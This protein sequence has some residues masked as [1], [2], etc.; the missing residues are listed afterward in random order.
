MSHRDNLTPI[1]SDISKLTQSEIQL[2]IKELHFKLNKMDLLLN[3]AHKSANSGSFVLYENDRLIWSENTY[4]LFGWNKSNLEPQLEAFYDHISKHDRDYVK[5]VIEM[6]FSTGRHFDISFRWMGSDGKIKFINSVGSL[7]ID[8]KTGTK[9]ITG[10]SKDVS[11]KN[12]I[13]EEIR[14]AARKLKAIIETS[15]DGYFVLN[16][17]G[18]ITEFNKSF[19]LMTGYDSSELLKMSISQLD[20]IESVNNVKEHIKKVAAQGWDQFITKHKRK[21]G[22]II[23]LDIST[24]YI[25]SVDPAFICFARDITS[26]QLEKELLEAKFRIEIFSYSHT[27]E[28]LLQ[29]CLEE[30]KELTYSKIGFYHFVE[31]DQENLH[32][33]MWSTNTITN[34]C[35]AEGKDTHYE[36]SKA[37]VWVDCVKTRK[38]I[39]HNDYENLKHKTGLPE[40]HA[41]FIREL[42]V[43]VIKN[44]KIKAILGVGNKKTNYVSN[45]IEVVTKL[46]DL[47]WDIVERKRAEEERNKSEQK[48]LELFE[49]AYV[50]IW[51]EDFSE[52]KKFIDQRKYEGVS[53][54][55]EYFEKNPEDIYKCAGLIKIVSVNKES[56]RLFGVN[57][58]EELEYHLPKYFIQESWSVFTAEIAALAEGSQKFESEIEICDL[59]GKRRTLQLAVSISMNSLKTWERVIVSFI[60]ITQ[61]KKSEKLLLASEQKFRH[62]YEYLPVGSIIVDFNSR[63]IS[64][65][66]AFSIF[67][68]YTEEE[69]I[70]KS[71]AEISFPDDV[72][73]GKEDMQKLLNGLAEI[74]VVEKRYVRKDGKVVWGSQNSRLLNDDDGR[75]QFYIL[76]IIDINDR[77]FDQQTLIES[78]EKFK[79]YVNNSPAGIMVT[80]K[81]GFYTD[82]NPAACKIFGYNKEEIIGRHLLEISKPKNA[83]A[84]KNHFEELLR[85]GSSKGD[86]VVTGKP[87]NEITLYVETAK[88]NEDCLIGF[89]IDVT[90]RVKIE[91]ALKESEEKFKALFNMS[92]DAIYVH[93][94]GKIQFVN[95]STVKLLKY[96][97]FEELL[98]IN[99]FDIIHPDY[100]KVVKER[101]RNV[102]DESN[103]APPLYEKYVCYDGSIVDV[104]VV[105]KQLIIN[106]KK[107]FQVLA[108]DITERIKNEKKIKLQRDLNL[109]L[110]NVKNINEAAKTIFSYAKLLLDV[111]CGGLY[112]TTKEGGLKIVESF[113]FS[114][115]FRKY[116]QYHASDSCNARMIQ[117]GN[118]IFVNYNEMQNS[119]ST[120]MLTEGLKTVSVIPFL[121]EGE[122]AAVLYLASHIVKE[123]NEQQRNLIETFAF[124]CG[125]FIG[126]LIAESELKVSE[127]KFRNF[128]EADLACDYKSLIDGTLIECN[129]AFIKM[130]EFSS[131]EEALAANMHEIYLTKEDR[132][133][134]LD[135]LKK[136]KFLEQIETKLITRKGKELI[137]LENVLADYD[138][139]GNFV[140]VT[141]Y[142][143][144]VTK[145]KL[146]ER[147]LIDSEKNYR[148]L[149]KSMQSGF[150]LHEIILNGKG[151][152]VDYRF[153]SV[154]PMF[155]KLTAL[156]EENII[157]KTVLQ[158]L[159]NLEK[160]WIETYGKVALTGKPTTYEN[161][162]KEIG[163]YFKVV[164]YSP[165][166]YKFATII[167]DITDAKIAEAKIQQLS[168]AVEQSPLCIL[169]TDIEGNIEYVNPMFTKQT[170]YTIEEVIGKN[171]RILKADSNYDEKYNKLWKR[172]KSGKEWTGIFKNKK[173]NGEIYW[174]SAV[175]SPIRDSNKKI[176]N[177]IAIK[178]DITEKI[179]KNKELEAYRNHLEEIVNLRTNELHISNIQLKNEIIK[180]QN[181]QELLKD[182][183]SKEKELN[184]IKTRF[185]STTSHEFRTP[186]TSVLSSAELMH[187][188]GKKWSENKINEHIERI[189]RSVDYLVKLLD[190]ILT[191]NRTESGKINFSPQVVNL[192]EFCV[193]LIEEA[194]TRATDKHI[195][196]F[197]YNTK[198]TMFNLD[199]KLLK[200]IL[201]NLVVNAIK[202]SPEGGKV[203]LSVESDSHNIKFRV[204]DKGIGIPKEETAYIFD[205]FYRSKNSTNIQGTGLGL[206]IV[207]KS[208]DLHQGKISLVSQINA[209]TTFTVIIPK[210]PIDENKRVKKIL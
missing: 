171:P 115:V 129:N 205:S 24:T 180:Q 130:L 71:I 15:H 39:V 29:K 139:N 74:P 111:D 55:R 120:E 116:I 103:A 207:K 113:G 164:V 21:D 141:G 119:G 42:V 121:F 10:I 133:S 40:G 80:N 202:Y 51:E 72:N 61:K 97:S 84:A 186:L 173:K 83:E 87:G 125:A 162:S 48:Y 159:P 136:R 65:N 178:E 181:T 45:D 22:S 135:K 177:Y 82:A 209:G 47:A 58:K 126:K 142:M 33:Q 13:E 192:K 26:A 3:K 101:M 170:G 118:S 38:P 182:A 199:L 9:C 34:I 165:A 36:I 106:G 117:S 92:P 167:E 7:T 11:E 66:K 32:L 196:N 195:L 77:K 64:A 78:E 99:I 168:T 28:E 18:Y 57:T 134:F 104:E 1:E 95:E 23:T 17:E 154:N 27:L 169:I 107:V 76:T 123:F 35:S 89:H 131:K 176:T 54:F 137:V 185:I 140:G 68:G 60:D 14:K 114:A 12:T 93:S 174:E 127:Q 81:D 188:Y 100:H 156:K 67:I 160:Q 25:H 206:A 88:I 37:G 4:E 190:D 105:A 151:K 49:E 96:P 73:V 203:I 161:Y 166:K 200:F 149:F 46:A 146:N 2:L 70:G 8:E 31:E 208:V 16:E 59:N 158:V 44:N 147:A 144:D 155:E 90:D 124:Q 183:L 210:K 85:N 143:I 53:N 69:L 98:N 122:I 197:R 109:E 198:S 63:F 56:L 50:P 30:T 138:E 184:E 148:D 20:V 86:F 175:L 191:I 204:S 163:K 19:E 150:A 91:S 6:T 132:N 5:N 152:P 112:I 172:I 179:A 189:R 193:D 62:F 194:K 145:M 187:K 41:P 110:V 108:G 102:Q 201:Q 43:P 75:P 153:I 157:G 52:I 79:S 128:F 94:G